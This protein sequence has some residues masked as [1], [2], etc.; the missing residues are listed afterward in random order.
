MSM[1]DTISRINELSRIQKSTGLDEQQKLE[2]AN[3]RKIYLEA[4]KAS[5]RGQL[6]QIEI[7]DDQPK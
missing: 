1:Q 4:I 5:L 7:V 6:D 2:Q 3:L